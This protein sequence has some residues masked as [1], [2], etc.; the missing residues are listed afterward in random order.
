MLSQL[1]RSAIGQVLLGIAP[2]GRL[3]ALKQV[4]APFV[5]DDRFR[6]QFRRDADTSRRVSSAFTATL[7]DADADA[8]APWLASEFV[9]GVTLRDAVDAAGTLTEELTLRLAAGLVA[10]LTEIHRAGLIHR[11]LKPSNVLLAVD[12]PCVIDFC[13]AR[14]TNDGQL[15]GSPGFMSPEQ[16][17]E[18]ELTPASDVFSLGSVLVMACTGRGPFAGPSAADT[19]HDVVHAEPDLNILSP[20]VRRIVEPCLAK[21]PTRRPT[22]AELLILVGEVAPS[23][24][25]W[26]SAVSK[27]I[28]AQQAGVDKFLDR[29]EARV[30]SL[31]TSASTRSRTR[32]YVRG[33]V[34]VGL[35][36]LVCVMGWVLH[37]APHSQGRS[38]GPP[39]PTSGQIGDPFLGHLDWVF[40]VAFSPD[41]RTLATGS[42]DGTARLWDVSLHRQIDEPLVGHTGYVLSLA[43]SPDGHILATASMDKTV[44][45]W[46]VATHRQIG[47]PLLGHSG[48]VWSVMFSPDGRTLATA[49]KDETVRLWDVATHRQTGDPLL[50]HTDSVNSVMFSPDGRTLATAGEDETVRLW[51][52]AT[53]RQTGDPLLGHTDSVNSVAFSPD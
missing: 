15:V 47:D 23:G 14:P 2:D 50:G 26:P 4:R 42:R 49:S 53:H 9:A 13:T 52:V 5:E 1:G 30:G 45:L 46:D 22:P 29:P 48:Y 20:R 51:D 39:A 33:S 34:L 17:E 44:R 41:G 38:P 27:L 36:A 12:G 16:V 7:I 32:H 21:D 10:A 37:P 43:F 28:A 25:L 35:A 40:S 3:V 6:E 31:G 11:A 19:M 8:P 18:R 24:W